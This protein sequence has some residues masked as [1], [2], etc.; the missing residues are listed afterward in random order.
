AGPDNAI[1]L[2]EVGTGQ[3]VHT[4]PGHEQ[5]VNGL[6]FSPDGKF[7]VSRIRGEGLTRFWDVKT[8][9]ESCAIKAVNSLAF[10]PDG[11]L[12]AFTRKGEGLIRLWDVP[13]GQESRTSKIDAP[14]AGRFWFAPDGK[15][16]V[17]HA[18]SD[19]AG[20]YDPSSG[21]ELHRLQMPF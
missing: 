19:T 18:G 16:L 20:L 12:L 10:S 5:A 4:L 6:V 11:K 2:W 3:Q 13:T 17:T 21:K 7:L 15:L 9:K 14:K 8:G 1:I